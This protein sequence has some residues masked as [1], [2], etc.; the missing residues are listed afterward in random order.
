MVWF[1]A[2][3]VGLVAA[4]WA[5]YW[6]WRRRVDA[7][8]AEGADIEWRRF[9]EYEPEFVEGLTEESF[10]KVYARV[11]L[12]RF[13]AYVLATVAAF[14]VSLPVSFILLA[15]SVWAGEKFGLWPAPIE[16]VQSVPLGET[17]QTQSWQCSAQCQLYIAEAFS[18]FYYFFG[19]L[20]IWLAIVAFFMRRY[21]S[22]RPGYLREEII[23]AREPSKED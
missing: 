10:R 14:V 21:H 18:G 6:R 19:I 7:E 2:I 3:L 20:M 15:G 13:P 16:I 4:A 8:I 12:P 9:R 11:H 23:R 22:R 17:A 1:F 5:L